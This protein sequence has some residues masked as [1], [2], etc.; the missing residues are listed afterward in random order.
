MARPAY[1]LNVAHFEQLLDDWNIN[2]SQFIEKS[3]IPRRTFQNVMAGQNELTGR[4]IAYFID[5]LPGAT[6]D[7]L[8]YRTGQLDRVAA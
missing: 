7:R 1:V 6:F 5:T 3:G 8:F 2:K 4:T